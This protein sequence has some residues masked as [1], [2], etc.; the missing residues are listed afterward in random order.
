MRRDRADRARRWPIVP[1]HRDLVVDSDA[2][3][4]EHLDQLRSPASDGFE[5]LKLIVER[6]GVSRGVDDFHDRSA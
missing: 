6:P 4:G 5:T 1:L 2:R 3:V